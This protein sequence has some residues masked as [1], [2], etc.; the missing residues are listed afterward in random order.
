[1]CTSISEPLQQFYRYCKAG[2]ENMPTAIHNLNETASEACTPLVNAA[3]KTADFIEKNWHTILAYV[4]AWGVI[5]VTIGAMYG[6]EAVSIPLTIGLLCGIGFGVV[7]GV[8]AVNSFDKTGEHSPWNYLNK[9]IQQLDMYGTRQIVL[10]AV[11]TAL[12]AASTV[13][14]YLMGAVFGIL[15]G[16]QIA[17]KA[18][19]G[20]NLGRDPTK[21]KDK[22]AMQALLDDIEYRSTTAL[23]G[24]KKE[25]G[26][27]KE[28]LSRYKAP[29]DLPKDPSP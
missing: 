14:P 3:T 20:Q 15:I 26:D 1:M 10:A 28:E 12:L 24:F 5:T 21:V 18:G 4:F 16:Y 25:I 7:A 17:I 19:S 11:V 29:N 23:E 6:F 22:E 13:Y 8:L 27:L 9:G 2:V